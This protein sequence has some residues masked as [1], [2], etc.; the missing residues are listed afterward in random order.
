[1][2]GI[3][4]KEISC[5]RCGCTVNVPCRKL[6]NNYGSGKRTWEIIGYLEDKGWSGLE[7][8]LCPDCTV[9]RPKVYCAYYRND[10]GQDN[11]VAIFST[12]EL[13]EHYNRVKYEHYRIVCKNVIDYKV[14]GY[15]YYSWLLKD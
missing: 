6:S 5:V 15:N 14:R 10:L 12:E 3:E 11:L 1:M 8:A 7:N 9:N 13:A 2:D 4:T